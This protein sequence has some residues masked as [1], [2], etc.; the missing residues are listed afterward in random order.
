MEVVCLQ[1]DAFWESFAASF[2][3][4]GDTALKQRLR[5]AFV[6]T[7]RPGEMIRTAE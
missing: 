6:A 1:D 5:D 3:S 4:A 7:V 2:D